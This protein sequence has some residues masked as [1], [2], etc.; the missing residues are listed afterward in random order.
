[1]ATDATHVSLLSFMG[2]PAPAAGIPHENASAVI[3]KKQHRSFQI[4]LFSIYIR[5]TFLYKGCRVR[6][7]TAL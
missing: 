2:A 5:I 6:P 3:S 4:L 7:A 1:M